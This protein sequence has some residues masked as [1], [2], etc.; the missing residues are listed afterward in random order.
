MRIMILSAKPGIGTGYSTV[1]QNIAP[2]LK[3][4][5]HDVAITAFQQAYRIEEYK[6]IQVYP[7]LDDFH[8]AGDINS[9]IHSLMLNMKSHQTEA[10]LCLFQGDSMYNAFTQIHPNTVWYV[11][12]EGQIIYKNHPTLRDARKVKRVISMTKSASTQL[13]KHGIESTTIYHGYNPKVFRKDYNTRLTELVTI[14]FP[15]ENQEIVIP[16]NKLPELKKKMQVQFMVGFNGLNFGVRKR[17]ERLI[18]AFSIFAE[19]K[20]RVHLHLHTPPIHSKGIN[21][22]E[23]L[24]Y[25][26][27]KDKVT[28]SYS[29]IGVSA[30]SEH[31]LNILYNQFDAFAS[32]SS[33]EGAGLPHFESMACGIPQIVPRIDPFIEYMGFDEDS[34][35]YL[36][37]SVPQLTAAGEIRGLVDVHSMAEKMETLYAYPTIRKNMGDNAQKWVQQFTWDKIALQFD[38]VFRSING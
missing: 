22:L 1:V 25:Y 36:A 33:G 6:G 30:W 3:K 4:L 24:E 21:L 12:I 32:A 31:A 19:A 13:A 10:L 16:A 18:E 9:Q 20:D 7:L 23:V 11:P 37:D 35:G 17:I 26:H 15:S 28:F 38:Q 27:I 5:G 8:S 2:E 29:N 14:Y 34:R